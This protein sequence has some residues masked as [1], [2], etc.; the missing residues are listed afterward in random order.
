MLEVTPSQEY[1]ARQRQENTWLILIAGMLF[2]SVVGAFSLVVSGRREFLKTL[3]DD[4]TRSLER[5]EGRLAQ[6]QRIALLGNWGMNPVT[7]QVRCSDEAYHIFCVEPE[8]PR[9]TLV[10]FLGF[11]HSDDR[12]RVK[13]CIESTLETTEPFDV[14]HKIVLPDGTEKFVHQ[15]GE[16]MVDEGRDVTGLIAVIQDVTESQALNRLKSEFISTV[17]HEL[18]TPL[19]SI[20]GA[21]GL[22]VG[23]A[24]GGL[25]RKGRRHGPDHLQQRQSPG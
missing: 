22:I 19:T 24:T 15:H 17:S 23:G 20:K 3:V 6:A 12:E 4:R 25:A 16:L 10:K 1:L 13:N 7:R 14:E 2:T 21:L 5:S 8:A 18:R 11:V 9:I